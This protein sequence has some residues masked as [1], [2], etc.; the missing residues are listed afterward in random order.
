[1]KRK[2][3]LLIYTN[4]SSFVEADFEIL[5]SDLEVTR[6]QFKSVKGIWKTA[7]ELIKQLSFLLANVRKFDFY[8][9]W[10]ADQHALLP[11]LFAKFTGSKS[12]VVVGGYDV[13]RIRSLHYGVFCSKLR[14]FTA[15]RAMK[16]STLNLPVSRHVARKVKALTRK[17][18]YTLIY[19]CVN[20]PENKL[21]GDRKTVITVGQ[22]DTERTCLLKGIDTFVEVARLLPDISFG[23]TGY[24]NNQLLHFL[25]DFPA[26]IRLLGNVDHHQLPSYYLQAKV[27]CQL[28]RSE[29]FGIAL[30]EAILYGCVPLVTHEGGMP[31]IVRDKE[32]IV[33]RDPPS[34]ARKISQIFAE[35]QPGIELSSDFS[36]DTR[37]NQ[38]LKLFRQELGV[39][40]M[41]TKD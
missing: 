7:F 4:F 16:Q 8:Y 30:A 34:I 14:G 20:L 22:I 27:Y 24:F 35:N 12:Y 15:L 21:Q 31:E 26:N 23:I 13:C 38:I 1:M 19:N 2:K 11:V 37:K 32:L 25:N 5:S 17:N 18:N 41:R 39:T 29:S 33:R 10:F 6:Y 36:F 40:S 9:I 3:V 28:S